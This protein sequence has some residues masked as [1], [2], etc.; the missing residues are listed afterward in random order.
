[1]WPTVGWIFFPG[2]TG[3]L[4]ETHCL[5]PE[6]W[7]WW[8]V[9]AAEFCPGIREI[10][11]INCGSNQEDD[12][13]DCWSETT[14]ACRTQPSLRFPD[15]QSLCT[16]PSRSLRRQRRSQLLQPARSLLRW[17]LFRSNSP[18]QGKATRHVPAHGLESWRWNLL[19]RDN[20][21]SSWWPHMNDFT[22][23]HAPISLKKALLKLSMVQKSQGQQPL[24][25]FSKPCFYHGISTANLNRWIPDFWLPS[26]PDPSL[27][28]CSAWPRRQQK[29][30]FLEWMEIGCLGWGLELL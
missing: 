19:F 17:S 10:S 27:E 22:D 21:G 18:W 24:G 9:Q 11:L 14:G 3:F 8:R 4:V 30:R 26:T 2:P 1:M 28:G 5:L 29:Q 23:N 6:F 16:Q 25:M 13:E 7:T 15:P 12:D 20:Q